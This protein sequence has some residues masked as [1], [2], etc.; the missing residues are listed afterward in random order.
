MAPTDIFL[1]SRRFLQKRAIILT[2][3]SPNCV[4][5]EAPN[6]AI[7]I[8]YINLFFQVLKNISIYILFII[9]SLIPNGSYT[10]LHKNFPG[11]EV[12]P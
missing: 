3:P 12:N 4:L 10:P 5:F 9:F 11:L 8:T 2:A 1:Y 6:A 7:C